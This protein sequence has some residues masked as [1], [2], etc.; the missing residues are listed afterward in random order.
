MQSKKIESRTRDDERVQ[1]M[2]MIM[3]R[4]EGP[5]LRYATRILGDRDRGC[6]VV[7]ETFLRLW[8]SDRFGAPD[9]AAQWL[10]TVCR[11]RAL[12]VL[13]KEK[14][15]VSLTEAHESTQAAAGS[16]P[17]VLAEAREAAS[18]VAEA[19]EDLPANQQEVIRLKFQNGFSYKQIAGITGLS[20]SGVGLHIHAAMQTLRRR[21][22]TR[23]LTA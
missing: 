3:D 5:L 17:Q 23:G 6:D 4:H 10:F 14:R 1:W 2:R 11:N 16:G 21:F 18:Q 9:N 15:M 19:L 22:K 8:K 13:R 7:Q 12:D 20:I